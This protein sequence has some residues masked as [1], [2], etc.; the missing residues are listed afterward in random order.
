MYVT[1]RW[2]TRFRDGKFAAGVLHLLLGLRVVTWLAVLLESYKCAGELRRQ[3][4]LQSRPPGKTPRVS[5]TR[6]TQPPQ[7]RG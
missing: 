6:Q 4:T 7:L 2:T 5:N 3:R 1:P